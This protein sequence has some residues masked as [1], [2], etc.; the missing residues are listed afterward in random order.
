MIAKDILKYA[1]EHWLSDSGYKKTITEIS[2]SGT[3]KALVESS[4]EIFCFDDISRDL[5]KR[6]D[7]LPTSADGIIITDN[8]KIYLVEFKSGFK[9][10][11][12]K[13]NLDKEKASCEYK[14]GLCNDYWNLFF[15]HQ[16][17]ETRQLIDSIREKAIESYITLEKR[18]FPQCSDLMSAKKYELIFIVVI[19][20]DGLDNMESALGEL[21]LK[22]PP[23]NNCFS[24][25]RKSLKHCL[26]QK[27]YVGNDYYYD[28]IKVMS[29][30]D[31]KFFVNNSKI[32][33]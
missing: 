15:R 27:D 1:Q 4:K 6:K 26:K 33:I 19:D 20:E 24:D 25:I 10:K 31:F 14:N 21:S 9:K 8:K 23:A 28:D 16:K 32:S 17:R 12:T 13:N 18:L 22:E 30:Y 5:Y 2:K 3:S 7:C 11:I 29:P